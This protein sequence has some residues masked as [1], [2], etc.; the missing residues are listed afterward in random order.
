VGR[1]IGPSGATSRR[2]RAVPEIT[3]IGG[4]GTVPA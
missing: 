2:P 4:D 3:R 1:V